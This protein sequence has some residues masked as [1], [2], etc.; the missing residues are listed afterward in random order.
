MSR[1]LIPFVAGAIVVCLLVERAQASTLTLYEVRGSAEA[2]RQFLGTGFPS[3]SDSAS[4]GPFG[5]AAIAEVGQI[6]AVQTGYGF[7]AVSARGIFGDIP[8]FIL[9]AETEIDQNVR[10]DGTTNEDLSFHYT[11]NGGELRLFSHGRVQELDTVPLPGADPAFR[12]GAFLD[13]EYT[14]RPMHS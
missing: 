6:R 4:F 10:N 3:A 14:I 7:N 5:G 9:H 12:P 8:S 1:R 13:A 11:I 2:S